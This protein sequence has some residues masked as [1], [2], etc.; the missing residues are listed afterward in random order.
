MLLAVDVGNSNTVVGLCEAT[1]NGRIVATWRLSTTPDRMPD[2]WFAILAPLLGAIHRP[3]ADIHGIVLSSVVPT[4]TTWLTEMSRDRFG[5]EPLIVSA[6]LDLGFHVA[7]DR[8]SEVGADRLANTMAAFARYG[9]PAVVIDFGTA[10]NFDVVSPTGDF[11]GGAIAPGLMISLEALTGRAARL[12]AVDLSLPERVIGTNTITNIQSGLV[13]G[14]LAML[15]GMIT[16]FKDELGGNTKII[17]TGGLAQR[18]AHATTLIDQYDPDLVI[19]GLRLIYRRVS[20]LG[21]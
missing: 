10:T 4:V 16:R 21:R 11:L 7:V 8:P 6:E 19:E 13:L 14:Y 1:E 2:E 9:G 12:F 5:V 18:F 20:G 17:A 3:V 15:E